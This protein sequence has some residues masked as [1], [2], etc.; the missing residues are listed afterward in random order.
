MDTQLIDVEDAA[1]ILGV[2]P[3][4]FYALARAGIVP[5]VHLGRQL[6]VDPKALERWIQEGGKAL[7]GGWKRKQ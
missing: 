1:T 2:T 6:R 3:S 5:V 7:P 4:R